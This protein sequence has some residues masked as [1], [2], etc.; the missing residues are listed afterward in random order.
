[1]RAG[2][3]GAAVVFLAILGVLLLERP[4]NGP[5]DRMTHEI[6]VAHRAS[7]DAHALERDPAAVSAEADCDRAASTYAGHGYW[8]IEVPVRVIRADGV[9]A[10]IY[11]VLPAADRERNPRINC[12]P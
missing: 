3:I 2:V 1:M 9:A 10:D 6:C 11:C 8:R 12:V 7:I 4:D 5:A